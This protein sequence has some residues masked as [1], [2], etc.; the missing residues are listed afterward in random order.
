MVL[1]Q[2]LTES[3]AKVNSDFEFGRLAMALEVL[4][5]I[6]ILRDLPMTDL[7]IQLESA[8]QGFLIDQGLLDE[9]ER[10][11]ERLDAWRAPK[12]VSEHGGESVTVTVRGPA[13]AAAA[14]EGL[15]PQARRIHASQRERQSRDDDA[16]P[17]SG[18]QPFEET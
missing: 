1:M 3:K 15:I 9:A 13:S 11:Y 17:S 16:K 5:Q 4:T 8:F 6:R 7:S 18:V 12:F 10:W 14:P 2:Y